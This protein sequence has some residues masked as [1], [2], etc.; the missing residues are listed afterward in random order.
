M[1]LDMI[2]T[3]HSFLCLN[4]VMREMAAISH[5]LGIPKITAGTGFAK[6]RSLGKGS[7]CFFR[8]VGGVHVRVENGKGRVLWRLSIAMV[9][10]EEFHCAASRQIIF[11]RET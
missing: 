9:V 2:L 8:G 3:G 7:R 4:E 1:Y 6:A 10:S 11:G 5:W